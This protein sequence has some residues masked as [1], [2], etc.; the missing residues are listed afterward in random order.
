[1]LWKFGLGN[2]DRSKINWPLERPGQ[3]VA[4]VSGRF[5][6]RIEVGLP[7]S[8]LSKLYL[9]VSIFLYLIGMGPKNMHC[10]TIS[11]VHAKIIDKNVHGIIVGSDKGRSKGRVGSGSGNVR[12]R[13]WPT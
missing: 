2:Y 10:F 13:L 1:M 5:W 7:T 6:Q 12:G 3:P 11:S 8:Y 4:S 9:F